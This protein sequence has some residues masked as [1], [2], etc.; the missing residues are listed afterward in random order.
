M[1]LILFL[2]LC[3]ICWPLAVAYVAFYFLLGLWDVV[4]IWRTCTRPS[5]AERPVD[6]PPWV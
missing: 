2:I 1:E 5:I 6:P 4:K 3:V